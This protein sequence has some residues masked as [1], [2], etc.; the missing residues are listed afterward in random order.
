MRKLLLVIA[1][2]VLFGSVSLMA[3]YPFTFDFDIVGGSGALELKVYWYNGGHSS[4]YWPE[5]TAGQKIVHTVPVS[6]GNPITKVQVSGYVAGLR[7]FFEE[8]I[9]IGPYNYFVV[10]LSPMVVVPGPDPVPK[11]GDEG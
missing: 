11:G 6:P 3:Q 1:A 2:I 8:R 7:Y 4:D 10:D 5:V 9:N